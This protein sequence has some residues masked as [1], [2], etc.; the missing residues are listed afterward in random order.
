[1]W[2][3]QVEISWLFNERLTGGLWLVQAEYR[4]FLR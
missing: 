3:V 1:M 2:T 4:F